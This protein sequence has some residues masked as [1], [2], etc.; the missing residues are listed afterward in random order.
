MR[1]L[2]LDE[3]LDTSSEESELSGRVEKVRLDLFVTRL[4]ARRDPDAEVHVLTCIADAEVLPPREVG[5][6]D[7]RHC[8]LLF[9]SEAADQLLPRCLK[10][11]GS[12]GIDTGLPKRHEAARVVRHVGE[13]DPAA[14]G[15]RGLV[16]GWGDEISEGRIYVILLFMYSSRPLLLLRPQVVGPLPL[17]FDLGLAV[18][19]HVPETD[20]LVDVLLDVAQGVL[21]GSFEVGNGNAR[22]AGTSLLAELIQHLDKPLVRVLILLVDYP[23]GD[24]ES[25][26]DI[27]DA[28]DVEEGHI[29]TV[30]FVGVVD[31]DDIW[32]SLPH[33]LQKG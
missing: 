14:V 1:L 8:R 3:L 5:S 30:G 33:L 22:S 6:K 7:I 31:R 17:E 24:I 12:E 13:R 23:K 21:E 16:D 25:R 4:G 15:N 27:R 28:G 18:L 11:V 29:E 20:L 10:L 26:M 32:E 2:V 9:F 19:Q